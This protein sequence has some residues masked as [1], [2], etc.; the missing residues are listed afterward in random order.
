MMIGPAPMMR[1]LSISVLLGILVK[2]LRGPAASLFRRSA[3]AVHQ[4]TISGLAPGRLAAGP[5]ATLSESLFVSPLALFHHPDKPV[6]QISQ[7]VRPRARLRVPLE[8]ER[9]LVGERE[10]LQRAIEERD[11]GNARGGRQ[12]RRIDGEAVVL[13]GN[14]HLSG[15]LVEHR[16]V[17][18]MVAE[19][20][21]QR[22][23]AHCQAEKLVTKADPERRYA[24]VEKLAD[25][26][27]RVIAGLGIARPVR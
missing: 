12:R 24:D 5:L 2:L 22:L 10:P 7:I 6:E 15:I 27:D 1:M 13:A 26:A 3:L 17:G 18:A 25:R 21:L 11:V 4:C 9:W 20:H 16:M 8:A 23:P 14:Q 19:F